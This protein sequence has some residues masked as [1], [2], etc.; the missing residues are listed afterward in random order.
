M[1]F[2]HKKNSFGR[3]IKTKKETDSFKKKEK[4]HNNYLIKLF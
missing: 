1:P 4:K 2:F 3:E